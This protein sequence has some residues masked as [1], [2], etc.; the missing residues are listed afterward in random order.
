MPSPFPGMDPFI[1]GQRWSDFHSDFIPE[2]R[3]ALVPKVRPR[4]VVEVQERV[5]LEHRSEEDTPYI[6][7]DLTVAERAG[8]TAPPRGGT[9]TAVAV[10]TGV[11]QL[12][13]PVPHRRRELF[14]TLRERATGA[15]VTVIELL[16]P[17]NKRPGDDGQ[18]EYLRKRDLVLAS[19]AHLV[20][21][22]LLR[23]GARLP[24]EGELPPAEHYAI[25]SRAGDRPIADIYYWSLRDPLPQIR[26]P[27]ADPDDDVTLDL[28]AVFS[29]VYD[30]A[31]YDYALDYRGPVAPALSDAE[32]EW[33]GQ[34][35]QKVG[36]NA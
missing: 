8:E 18:R 32:A 13:L 26:I 11:V 28:Q 36:P 34:V 20:E 3:A 1:E 24:V 15:V 33:V 5:Y 17:S 14:L 16:S 6:E 35:L 7:P 21:L 27:L 9:A 19:P 22:D 25:V 31:G 4:Y 12:P 29:S 2:L 23:G 10:A 30:R